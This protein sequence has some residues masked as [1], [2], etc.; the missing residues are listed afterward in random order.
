MANAE[1]THK[2][3][4]DIVESTAKALSMHLRVRK[5]FNLVSYGFLVFVKFLMSELSVV[6]NWEFG[7][8]KLEN[9]KPKLN[10]ILNE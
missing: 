8:P 5:C 9:P 10:L 2:S 1:R 4:Q 3:R 7:K 6:K